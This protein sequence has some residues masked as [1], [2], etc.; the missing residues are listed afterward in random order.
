MNHD[1]DQ[2]G[3][4]NLD[5]ALARLPIADLPPLAAR[6][7]LMAAERRLGR[8]RSNRWIERYEPPLLAAF[9]VGHLIWALVRVVAASSG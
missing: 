7:L 5:R 9:A 3:E 1:E 2:A 6:A 8:A 4:A